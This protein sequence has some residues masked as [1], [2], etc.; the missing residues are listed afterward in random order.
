MEVKA[1][2]CDGYVVTMVDGRVI[3]VKPLSQS[4]EPKE[5]K[6][7]E[8]KKERQSDPQ[9]QKIARNYAKA[10]DLIDDIRD[11]IQNSYGYGSH[12]FKTF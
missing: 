11:E 12:W 10:Q 8:T 4:P 9:S 5:D 6:P 2:V 3:S 7:K 1:Q